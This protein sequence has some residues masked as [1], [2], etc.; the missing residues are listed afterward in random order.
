MKGGQGRVRT[1]NELLIAEFPRELSTESHNPF[2]KQV[3]AVKIKFL[4]FDDAKKPRTQ[5]CSV[6][7]YSVGE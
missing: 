3:I 2:S 7:Q 4:A 1:D 5:T 6:T